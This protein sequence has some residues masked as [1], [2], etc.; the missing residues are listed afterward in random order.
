MKKPLQL[1]RDDFLSAILRFLWREW[2]ALGVAGHHEEPPVQHVIDPEALLLFTCS[3]GRYDQRLFDEVLD[4]LTQNGRF[5]N[6]QRLRNIMKHESFHGGEVLTAVAGWLSGQGYPVKWKLL[7]RTHPSPRKAHP[8]FFLFDGR[9]LPACGEADAGFHDN[10]LIRDSFTLRGYSRLFPSDNAT[11][12]FFRLRALMGVN[13]HADLLSFLL[14]KTTSYPREASREMHYS[15]KTVH[16]AMSDMECSGI[17]QSTKLGRERVYY[18]VNGELKLQLLR[19]AVGFR[20]I[21]WAVL[22][23]AVETVWW[24]VEALSRQ[25]LDPLLEASEI[26]VTVKPILQRLSQYDWMPPVCGMGK[27]ENIERLRPFQTMLEMK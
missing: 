25:S 20:W 1:F 11:C 15:Q 10:G 16:D 13:V 7:A 3:L 19:D 14:L 12:L 23:S 9:P 21:N 18:V 26:M 8:L 22:L 5:I 17:I 27:Q 6:I 4:W 24:K 2:T